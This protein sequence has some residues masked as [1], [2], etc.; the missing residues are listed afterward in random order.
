MQNIEQIK[1]DNYHKIRELYED[2]RGKALTDYKYQE[3]PIDYENFVKALEDKLLEGLILFENE[4]ATGLLVFSPAK[5]NTF[6]INAVHSSQRPALLKSLIG[7]LNMK[8]N[9]DVLSYPMLGVQSA[10]VKDI[11]GL[12]FKFVGQS[13]VKFDFQDPVSYRVL[14]NSPDVE[15]NE[16]K[17]GFWDNNYAKQA[18]E[19]IH[20]GFK[21]NKNS[22]FDPRF[23]SMEGSKDVLDMILSDQYGKF[24]PTQSRV[25]LRDGKLEGFCLTVLATEEKINI[26]LI[27]LRKSERN[28]GMGK[29]VLKS[30][31]GG[32]AKL[33]SEQKLPLKEIN[34]T[35]DTDNYPA[36]KMYRRLGFREEYYYPHAYL[37]FK[38]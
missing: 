7:L 9:C 23:K 36:L 32:F 37:K 17:L 24:I 5:C 8:K 12:G 15:L 38:N 27:A 13:I 19:I 3:T 16:C 25:L 22:N 2:F 20:L 35:V 30:V 1:L 21:N 10:D 33:I 31:I 14:R 11:S 28:K 18:V 34:A 4:E 29:L 26:P 6:E